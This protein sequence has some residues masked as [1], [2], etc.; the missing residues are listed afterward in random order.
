MQLRSSRLASLLT[1]TDVAYCCRTPWSRCSLR[2][3][4]KEIMVRTVG[5][6][7][8]SGKTLASQT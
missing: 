5:W 2:R 7:R 1:Q 6:P 8:A 3:L 4:A